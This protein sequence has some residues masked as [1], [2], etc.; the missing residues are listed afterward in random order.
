MDANSII[1]YLFYKLISNYEISPNYHYSSLFFN[2]WTSLDIILT[3]FSYF[4]LFRVTIIKKYCKLK[5]YMQL[6]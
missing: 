5:I 1:A 6:L 3:Q 2:K 4:F